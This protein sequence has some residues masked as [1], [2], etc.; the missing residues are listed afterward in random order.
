MPDALRLPLHAYGPVTGAPVVCLHGFLGRGRD[1]ATLAPRLDGL[2]VLAPDLPGHGDAATL[3]RGASVFEAAAEAVV[4]TLDAAGVRRAGLVGYSMGGRLALYLA[5][6]H[7]ERWTHLVLESASPGLPDAAARRER[8]TADAERAEAI[9]ADLRR[10][11]EAWYELPLFRTLTRRQRARLAERRAAGHADALAT[12]LVGMSTGAQPDLWPR[13]ATLAVPAT[14]IVGAEDPKFVDIA[15]RMAARA[16]RLRALV[17]PGASHNVH[18]ECPEAW[19][20]I[21]RGAL[22]GPHG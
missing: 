20:A 5:L 22:G 16:P 11:V 3:P 1:W 6:T 2:R 7:P 8:R 4:A 9:R 14:A 21:V 10:F 19:A 12:A 15:E 13:L 18:M 17:V